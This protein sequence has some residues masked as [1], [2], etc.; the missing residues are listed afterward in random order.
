LEVQTNRGVRWFVEHI[1]IQM[2]TMN[3]VAETAGALGGS[4]LTQHLR[5]LMQLNSLCDWQ[6]VVTYRH[7]TD[8]GQRSRAPTI[9]D[10]STTSS[11]TS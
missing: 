4:A 7:F 3:R 9:E 6:P 10:F 2:S 11:T 5:W 1:D 8:W